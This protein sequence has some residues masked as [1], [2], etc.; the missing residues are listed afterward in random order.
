MSTKKCTCKMGS[1]NLTSF[2]VFGWFREEVKFPA[3]CADIIDLESIS[4][5][6]KL[7]NTYPLNHF[8]FTSS[9]L[10]DVHCNI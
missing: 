5:F 7:I 9:L 10:L 3:F 4:L 2:D 6:D 1:C 8:D